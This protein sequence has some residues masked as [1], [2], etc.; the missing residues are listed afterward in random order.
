MEQLQMIWGHNTPHTI[1][2]KLQKCMIEQKYG[3]Q[4]KCI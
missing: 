2:A 1:N 3:I 4:C